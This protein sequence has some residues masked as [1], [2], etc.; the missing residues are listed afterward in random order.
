MEA[1]PLRVLLIES[2]AVARTAIRLLLQQLGHDVEAAGT[3]PELRVIAARATFDV[4]LVDAQ[5]IAEPSL[6]SLDSL[7]EQTPT[8]VLLSELDPV[9]SRSQFETVLVKPFTRP[10][11]AEALFATRAPDAQIPLVHKEDLLARLG[12]NRSVLA[13]M[14]EL[15]KQQ[16]DAHHAGMRAAIAQR[17]GETLRRLAHQANG[18]LANLAAPTAAIAARELEDI[19]RHCEWDRAEEAILK[20]EAAMNQVA[21]ELAA[22]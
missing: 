8:I 4:L 13:Q 1:P 3:E 21:R 15:L 12:G 7:R 22:M 18:S 11:L 19:A 16:A 9:E 17:D 2:S 14:T 6:G 5:W 10:Q 20:F